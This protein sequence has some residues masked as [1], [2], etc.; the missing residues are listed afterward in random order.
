MPNRIALCFLVTKNIVNLDVWKKWWEGNEHLINIY[1]HFSQVGP[2]TQPELLENAVDPVPTKWG[3]VSLINAEAQLYKKAIQDK[4]NV[5]FILI[6]DTCIPV[7]S[8]HKIY[9]RV[10]SDKKRG[11]VAYRSLSPYEFRDDVAPFIKDGECDSLLKKYGMYNRKVYAADQW[12]ALSRHNVQDFL[13]MLKDT[14][15]VRLYNN[16]I[17]VVPDSLAP[18]ELMYVNW[19]NRKYK[20]QLSTQFRSGGITFVDFKGKAIHP[21]DYKQVTK[22]L[23][24]DICDTNS[25]FARKFPKPI[26]TRLVKQTPVECYKNHSIRRGSMEGKYVKVS[27]RR[28]SPSRRKSIRKSRR[29]SGSKR[30]SRRRNGSKRKSV[31]K[32]VRKPRKSRSRRK[33]ARKPKK[34]RSRRKSVRK[35]RSRRKRSRK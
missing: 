33:S 20:G 3:D 5:S 4:R 26:E 18:D 1:A 34:S 12:K 28:K 7:R 22:N 19:M 35:S 24:D 16:C 2:I 9:Q 11:L 23:S 14:A 31:R 29:R 6:S 8:F 17:K 30:K 32:S 15:F 10:T 25:L 13:K 21:I 27:R